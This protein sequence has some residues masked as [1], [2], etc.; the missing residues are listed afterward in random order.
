MDRDNFRDNFNFYRNIFYLL[1]RLININNSK[2]DKTVDKMTRYHYENSILL[3]EKRELE[4]EINKRLVNKLV[5]SETSNLVF[6]MNAGALQENV[7]HDS[8]LV[9][10]IND[11][12]VP[13]Y[14][15]LLI[16]TH[17]NSDLIFLKSAKVK[18]SKENELL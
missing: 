12:I 8:A 13:Q 17:E 14:S 18:H 16:L 11:L 15:K 7:K 10:E 5:K 2:I 6:K 3:K 1:N 4:F 9:K